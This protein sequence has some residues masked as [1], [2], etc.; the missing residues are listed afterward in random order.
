[1]CITAFSIDVVKETDELLTHL[2]PINSVVPVVV[3]TDIGIELNLPCVIAELKC[4]PTKV[5]FDVVGVVP[6]AGPLQNLN[7]HSLEEV[8]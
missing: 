2:S 8:K 7:T 4:G 6:T 3:I 1:M 5:V